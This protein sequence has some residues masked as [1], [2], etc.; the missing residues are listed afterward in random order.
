MFYTILHQYTPLMATLCGIVFLVILVLGVLFRSLVKSL[1]PDL[2]PVILNFG[3]TV[4]VFMQA[5]LAAG[6][7]AL[8][9]LLVMFVAYL[10]H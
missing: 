10:L 8:I 4:V 7:V 2:P 1:M 5:V 3:I 6:S 9:M